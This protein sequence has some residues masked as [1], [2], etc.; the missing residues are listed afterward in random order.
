M[1]VNFYWSAMILLK[2]IPNKTL[3]LPIF[4]QELI[5]ILRQLKHT[6]NHPWLASKWKAKVCHD[7]VWLE[8][9]TLSSLDIGQPN[10]FVFKENTELLGSINI[11]QHLIF[12]QWLRHC[13]QLAIH[14]IQEASTPPHTHMV[15]GEGRNSTSEK[16]TWK[17]LISSR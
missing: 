3:F 17:K 6:L 7:T 8:R 5:S 4:K 13:F 10:S 16:I 14:E 11:I 9:L 1:I 15:G 2:N 12:W